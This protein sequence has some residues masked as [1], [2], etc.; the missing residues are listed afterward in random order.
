MV[1][2]R[3]DK[4]TLE[5]TTQVDLETLAIEEKIQVLLPNEAFQ[6]VNQQL[7]EK[8][9]SQELRTDQTQDRKDESHTFQFI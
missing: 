4:W 9:L 2:E 7:M 8:L 3:T 1:H 6:I 5:V